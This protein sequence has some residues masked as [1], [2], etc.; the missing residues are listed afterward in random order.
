MTSQFSK[1]MYTDVSRPNLVNAFVSK[2][3]ISLNLITLAVVV[4]LCLTY[5]LQINS[6][7]ASGYQI[8]DL[9][10]KITELTLANQRIEVDVREARSLNNVEKSVK[11]MGLVKAETPTYITNIDPE[12][13]LLVD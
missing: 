12:V 6:S 10:T 5:I 9:E 11:M 2:N 8:R 13:A 4:V 1:T 3:T 7:V